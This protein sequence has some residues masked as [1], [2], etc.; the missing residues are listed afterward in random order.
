M[1]M[2]LPD[3]AAAC[4]YLSEAPARRALSVGI[5]PNVSPDLR[6]HAPAFTALWRK[7]ACP[8]AIAAPKLRAYS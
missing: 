7:L 8:R 2:P 1:R 3:V 6:Q 4:F 5:C